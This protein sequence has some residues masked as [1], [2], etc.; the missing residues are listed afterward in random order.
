MILVSVDQTSA[1]LYRG[2]FPTYIGTVMLLRKCL[3][4]VPSATYESLLRNSACR[5]KQVPT[6]TLD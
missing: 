3:A 5:K 6:E 1:C 2:F 4:H